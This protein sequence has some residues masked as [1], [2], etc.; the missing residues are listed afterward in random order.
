MKTRPRKPSEKD[1]RDRGPPPEQS[2]AEGGAGSGKRVVQNRAVKFNVAYVHR[3]R[4]E[5]LGRGSP[6]SPPRL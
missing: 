6:G 3:D 5:Y 4:K 1:R 2:K